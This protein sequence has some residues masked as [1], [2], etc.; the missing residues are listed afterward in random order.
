MITPD[1][2]GRIVLPKRQGVER[3]RCYLARLEDDGT[4]VLTPA[5]VLPIKDV[6]SLEGE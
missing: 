1:A 6:R 3:A 5:R 2:R 4:V